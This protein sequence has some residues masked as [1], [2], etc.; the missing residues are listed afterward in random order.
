MRRGEGE[1]EGEEEGG[2]GE[3]GERE[4]GE[5]ER[6]GEGG[7]GREREGEGGR[8][9]RRGREKY[10]HMLQKIKLTSTGI[11][12]QQ[13]FYYTETNALWENYPKRRFCRRMNPQQT[14]SLWSQH[15]AEISVTEYKHTHNIYTVAKRDF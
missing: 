9:R 5:R 7:R 8:G 15:T 4:G 11:I 1:G 3:G 10:D 14:S 13:K 2:R 6:E 12:T